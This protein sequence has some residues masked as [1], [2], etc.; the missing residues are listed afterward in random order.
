M[1]LEYSLTTGQKLIHKV[2]QVIRNRLGTENGMPGGVIVGCGQTCPQRLLDYALSRGLK[3]MKSSPRL[4]ALANC[5]FIFVLE[6]VDRVLTY[7]HVS[8]LF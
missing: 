5:T 1:T 2:R 7:K 8:P 4:T 3:I 6:E